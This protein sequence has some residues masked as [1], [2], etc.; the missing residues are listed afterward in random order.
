MISTLQDLNQHTLEPKAVAKPLELSYTID[1]KLKD[2][3]GLIES[4]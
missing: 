2:L 4:F 3:K 1:L